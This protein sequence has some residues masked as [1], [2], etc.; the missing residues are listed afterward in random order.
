MNKKQ[1]LYNTLYN[2]KHGN[3]EPIKHYTNTF[4]LVFEIA[5]HVADIKD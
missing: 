4:M 5:Y 3:I 1:K 2:L